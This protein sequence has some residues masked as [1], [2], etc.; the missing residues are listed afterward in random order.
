MAVSDIFLDIS[1]TLLTSRCS[2]VVKLGVVPRDRALRNIMC[3]K[4]ES[5]WYVTLS[6][7]IA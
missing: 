6:P 4:D 7:V 1:G 3:D 5:R 2:A